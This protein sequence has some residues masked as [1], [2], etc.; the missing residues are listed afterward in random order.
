MRRDNKR[1]KTRWEEKQEEEKRRE[2]TKK[3][4]KKRGEGRRKYKIKEK[5]STCMKLQCSGFNV[6]LS[7]WNVKIVSTKKQVLQLHLTFNVIYSKKIHNILLFPVCNITFQ[8]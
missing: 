5:R 8:L 3:K 4:D 2:A 6:F 1:G 7:L